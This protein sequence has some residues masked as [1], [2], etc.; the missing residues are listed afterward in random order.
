MRYEV[1][2][3]RPCNFQVVGRADNLEDAKALRKVSG[4][5]VFLDGEV[6]QDTAWLWTWEKENESFARTTIQNGWSNF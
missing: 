4:D 1:R 6:C 2:F 3:G 5:I